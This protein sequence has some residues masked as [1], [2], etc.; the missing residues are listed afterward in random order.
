MHNIIMVYIH[1]GDLIGQ[2][3]MHAV[4]KNKEVLISESEMRTPL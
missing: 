1:V 3:H 2:Y 4:K